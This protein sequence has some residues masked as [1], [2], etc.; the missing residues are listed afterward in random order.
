VTVH[1]SLKW[2]LFGKFVCVQCKRFDWIQFTGLWEAKDVT[3]YEGKR[4]HG[5][6]N[7]SRMSGSQ[8]VCRLF[9]RNRG[10]I[11]LEAVI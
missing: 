7:E 5:A 6:M 11:I 3:E 9:W 10:V 8:V 4:G 2:D 1:L